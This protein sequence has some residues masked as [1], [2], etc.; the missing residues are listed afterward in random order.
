MNLQQKIPSR[1]RGSRLIGTRLA[2][3]GPPIV[4][5]V[6]ASLFIF[7]MARCPDIRAQSA[8]EKTPAI[9]FQIYQATTPTTRDTSSPNIVLGGDSPLGCCAIQASMTVIPPC[10]GFLTSTGKE[11]SQ[12]LGP[13]CCV[14]LAIWSTYP[15]G[16]FPLCGCDV[17][18]QD[19][20]FNP[21]CNVCSLP[22]GWTYS[23]D[24]PYDGILHLYYS[25]GCG[26]A[27]SN[28]NT[29][30][31]Q[32]C[33][34][35]TSGEV[36]YTIDAYSCKTSPATGNCVE[37]PL[38]CDPQFCNTLSCAMLGVSSTAYPYL[39][40]DNGYPNPATTS[41]RFG[42]TSAQAGQMSMTLVDILGHTLSTS[43]QFISAGDGSVVVSLGNPQPG[44]Y[45]CVREDTSVFL[46]LT[47][48]CSPAASR[49]NKT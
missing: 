38:I 29:L 7:L 36:C 41:I 27:L 40:I 20:S 8:S 21:L 1:L 6:I 12:D 46:I 28:G 2:A 22:P 31:F 18:F 13:C 14:N 43:S 16:C 39:T 25:G 47:E 37:G 15:G 30:N 5:I 32:F 42:F 10:G 9:S 3:H 48:R 34:Q 26:G 33:G 11:I 17:I 44:G 24:I 45:F 49:L 4:K 19:S 23:E 35:N